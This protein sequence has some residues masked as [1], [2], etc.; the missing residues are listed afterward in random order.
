MKKL[1]MTILLA[2]AMV[3]M[4]IQ[5]GVSGYIFNKILS[6]VS[7]SKILPK[8]AIFNAHHQDDA[9]RFFQYGDVRDISKVAIW[10]NEEAQSIYASHY[11]LKR[12]MVKKYGEKRSAC[13]GECAL[14]LQQIST[15]YST[16]TKAFAI[17]AS[18]TYLQFSEEILGER[19]SERYKKAL[20]KDLSSK[21]IFLMF[22]NDHFFSNNLLY[23]V[24]KII[25]S[26]PSDAKINI[27]DNETRYPINGCN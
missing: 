13:L 5:A 22:N 26:C 27:G 11:V 19:S 15:V 10:G 2:S 9:I 6:K 20:L 14:I 18:F 16:N 17:L 1:F 24:I 3:S 21:E 25:N 12:Y 4:P 23:S 7:N 8:A